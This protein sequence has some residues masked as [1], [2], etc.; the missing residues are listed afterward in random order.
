MRTLFDE[1]GAEVQ[2]PDESELEE[3]KKANEEAASLKEQLKTLED[4]S[5]GM[6]SLREALKRKD[7]LISDLQK[8][9]APVEAPKEVKA[10]TPAFDESRLRELTRAEASKVLLEAEINRSLSEY[11]DDDKKVV[12]RYFDK[13]SA[14]EELNMETLGVYMEQATRA[15]F[16]STDVRSRFSHTAG[17]RPPIVEETKKSFADSDAGRELAARLGMKLDIPSKKK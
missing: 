12:K 11:S 1:S 16:P 4:G 2:V 15:A 3:L 10:E 13:L 8:K 9:T 7:A 14:G 17:G 6:K 5:V